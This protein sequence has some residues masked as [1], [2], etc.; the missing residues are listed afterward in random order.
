MT[1]SFYLLLLLFECGFPKKKFLFQMDREW[2][3]NPF[4]PTRATTIWLFDVLSINGYGRFMYMTCHG[5]GWFYYQL[6]L[7][8]GQKQS[9]SLSLSHT[10]A[11]LLT[12]FLWNVKPLS[13]V[14]LMCALWFYSTS[15]KS[16]HW[17]QLLSFAVEC[18]ILQYHF[19][20][21]PLK[22]GGY[23]IR[24]YIG[25]FWILLR[26]IIYSNPLSLCL[27]VLI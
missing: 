2:D 27:S 18:S 14:S 22:I 26:S 3:K 10:Y 9:L 6:K 25:W 8:P 12:L 11:L 20:S 16:G 5:C 19:L 13:R 4:I 15:F 23:L 17:G 7:I 21:M 1:G 24:R